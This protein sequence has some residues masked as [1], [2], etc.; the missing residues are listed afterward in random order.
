MRAFGP[1]QR[2]SNENTNGLL[3]QYLLRRRDFKNLAQ[4]DLDAIALELND[5]PRQTSTDP[6]VQ[7]T[8]QALAEVLHDRLSL[9]A[10]RD[11]QV[12]ADRDVQTLR[13]C[14]TAIVRSC[15]SMG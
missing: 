9:Q 7:G 6:R 13:S 8:S 11:V 12:P 10:D 14:V 15:S 2:G 4:A 5:R 1:G 3:R